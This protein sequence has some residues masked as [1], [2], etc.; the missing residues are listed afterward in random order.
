MKKLLGCLSMSVAL[1]TAC[2]SS[3][4]EGEGEA[5]AEGEGEEGE[6]EEGEGEEGEGEEGEGEE[7]EGE[8]GEGEEGE[9]EDSP[10]DCS[11]PL[12]FDVN[13][14]S[15]RSVRSWHGLA[16][17][18]DNTM[19]SYDLATGNLEKTTRAGVSSL[20]VPAVSYTE[21]IDS[22][23][24]GDLLLVQQDGLVR[25]TPDGN[26]TRIGSDIGGG[27][28]V[29]VGPDGHAYVAGYEGVHRINLSTEETDLIVA[30]ELVPSAHDIDFSLDSRTM[31][32]GTISNGL[33]AVPLDD[34]LNR[35]GPPTR[36]FDLE[37]WM[38]AVV[39]DECGWVW[40]P[41]YFQSTLHRFNPAT[42]EDTFSVCGA[43]PCYPHGIT[44]GVDAAGWN[45][46]AIYAPRPYAPG[47]AVEIEVGVRE[48]K[49]AR[50]FRGVPQAVPPRGPREVGDET[51]D[52]NVD[53]DGDYVVDCDDTDCD[54]SP[55]CDEVCGNG[56]DD[57]GD[58]ASDCRDPDCD[59]QGTC[60]EICG[61]DLDDDEDGLFDCQDPS[62]FDPL[63][64]V[65]VCDNGTDDDDNF[66]RDCEDFACDSSP[67][68][69][70]ICGNDIDDD[71]DGRIDC[72]ESS[73][74]DPLTCVEVCG[75]GQDDDDNFAT[76]CQDFVCD[77]SPLCVEI[78]DNDIDDD[79]DGR[80]DCQE[81]SCA[82]L[83]I[84]VE[85]CDNGIDD[86]D[87]FA[88]DCEDFEC[89][90]SPSCVEVCDNDIDDDRDGRVDCQ[91][92]TCASL[93][94]CVENCGNGIDDDD[95]FGVDCQDFQCDV[96]PLC[97]EICDNDID[98]DND[99]IFDCQE[100]SCASSPACV[101]ICGNGI[102]DNENFA[103]DCQ[104]PTCTDSP[105][106]IELCNNSSDDDFDGLTDCADSFC[107]AEQVCAP[108][109]VTID[110]GSRNNATRVDFPFSEGVANPNVGGEECVA[111]VIDV[112]SLLTS[113]TLSPLCA[114]AVSTNDTELLLFSGQTLIFSNDDAI[115]GFCSA[116]EE[117]LNA[118]TYQLCVRGLSGNRPLLP[119]EFTVN[120][121]PL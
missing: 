18:T 79:N 72:Q 25:L 8:E 65:E 60:V 114:A 61:N 20:F 54:D 106:C 11:A 89:D 96:S 63:T 9:G 104:D 1:L 10:I 59:G 64:C 49:Y 118:G 108:P 13:R 81:F 78:C 105:L 16:F 66:A 22:A 85:I 27:Y 40:I 71:Q 39:V 88:T 90:V 3:T 57:D 74:F 17:A 29:T 37:A 14:R 7:G 33:W 44:F 95:D 69:V 28:G 112:V 98:D 53:D 58:F 68:C 97:V 21:Q 52:N 34:E 15:M 6:G 77:D 107:V 70:E 101:E 120:V 121:T 83:P 117:T 115:V 82:S 30:P 93:P 19:V 43:Q 35:S 91:E 67:L 4:A 87:N 75:N 48:G 56:V 51:C 5:P 31:Y 110:L 80:I 46:R 113:S 45:N 47:E 86:N 111:I 24:N 73:C 41:D 32:V 92:T 119:V 36:I 42:G 2:S 116:L 38:D 76:D 23:P 12:N 100:T 94:I 103:V 109:A 55:N 26:A 50:T 84:C 99:G 62:C 102:D